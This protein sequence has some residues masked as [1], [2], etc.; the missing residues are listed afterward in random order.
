MSDVPISTPTTEPS[1]FMTVTSVN[2]FDEQA[3]FIDHVISSLRQNN[4]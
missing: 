2:Q 1:S 4:E 3:D